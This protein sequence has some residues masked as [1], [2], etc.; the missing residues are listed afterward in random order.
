MNWTQEY[1][2]MTIKIFVI[3]LLAWLI[4]LDREF[5]HKPAGTKTH[6]LVG[7]GSTV[8]TIMS[9]WFYQE[10]K[11]QAVVDPSRIA[12]QIVTGI[13]FLGA[14]TIIQS[15]GSVTGLTTAASLWSVAGI[16]VAVGAGNYYLAV[17]SSAVIII[18][19]LVMNRLNETLENRVER[20]ENGILKK[21]KKRK[22]KNERNR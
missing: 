21:R 8:F 20:V 7:L 14:G 9:I 19:F 11:G 6:I 15:G 3:V 22:E 5:R 16:G 2:D 1:T 4:G 13:G 18:V 17:I 12:A 10:F